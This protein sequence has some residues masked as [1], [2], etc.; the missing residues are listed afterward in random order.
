MECGEKTKIRLEMFQSYKLFA[1]NI[2]N[3]E[4]YGWTH[5]GLNRPEAGPKAIIIFQSLMS[6]FVQFNSIFD[7]S[8]FVLLG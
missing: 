4:V 3:A 6:Q 2:E 8:Q 7:I 5:G 1:I